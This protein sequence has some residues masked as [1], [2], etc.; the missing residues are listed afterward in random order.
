MQDCAKNAG[1]AKEKRWRDVTL[2]AG[3]QG[4]GPVRRPHEASHRN[5]GV[6]RKQVG[7]LALLVAF[8]EDGKRCGQQGTRLHAVHF[9]GLDPRRDDG[10]VG[11]YGVRTLQGYV[12]VA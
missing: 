6:P 12:A 2:P 10:P 8:E 11:G 3:G 9:A 7:D 1:I 5:G 4:R